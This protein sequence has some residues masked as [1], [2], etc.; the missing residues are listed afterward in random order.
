M[1]QSG[2]L[3]SI[4]TDFLVIGS[5]LAG[6]FF[7]YKAADHGRVL[8]ITKDQICESSTYYAQGGVASVIAKN[9]SF[10]SHI[11]DTMKAGAGICHEDVVKITVT[12]G[13]ERIKE[14]IQLGVNF[15]KAS[16]SDDHEAFD[17]GREGGHSQRRI[18]HAEDNTG[19][20]IETT[21]MQK[22]LEKKNV[23]VLTHHML[24]DLL[25]SSKV[26]F[27]FDHEQCYGAYVLSMKDHRIHTILARVTLL[28][29]GGAGKVY[30]YTSNPDVATGD[31]VAAAYRAGCRI[32]NMEF[33][34]FHPTCLYH[35]E[36]KSFLISE[37]VRGE[38]GILKRR[39][40]TPFME[41]Y[42][43]LG[44]LAP[45]D[46]VARAIDREMKKSGDD[47]VYLDITQR[48]PQFIRERFPNI[49]AKCLSYGIDMT[50]TPIPVVPAAHYS[51]GGVVTD[52]DG[53]TDLE[54]LFAAGEVACTGLHG[55][56]RLASNS[57]LEGLVFG[58]RAYAKS[59]ETLKRYDISAFP[60]IPPW[61]ARE[62]V[63]PDEA[64][65]VTHNWDEIRRLMVCYVGI[66]RSNKRLARAMRRIALINSEITE[67]YWNYTITK[68]MLELR[69]IATVAELIIRSAMIRK[70]S[71]GLHYT[72]DYPEKDETYF[73]HDTILV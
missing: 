52:I 15:D 35:P 44:C 27:G 40:G 3:P 49:Y 37:A 70:E 7:A 48:D 17:L 54:G 14:L 1:P 19:K 53:Q 50:K 58:Q 38:G 51:C 60:A 34:Q 26:G 67:Y 41:D 62:A 24:I 69:N 10:E 31:G 13:P 12:T 42:H 56:N 43:E 59:L 4:S 2:Q 36:A 18:L 45:R 16:H 30:L 61:T 11:E 72:L 9:D 68:D 47:C 39:N 6:L 33:M 8:I 32:A 28:A 55:A 65:I 25:T 64:V 23:T 46:I 22:I 73:R 71:R 20:A 57:L 21:L 66:V 5:G 63:P 29:T